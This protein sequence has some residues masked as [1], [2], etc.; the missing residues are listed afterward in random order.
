V[1]LLVFKDHKELKGYKAKK[2]IRAIKA[3]K[4]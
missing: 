3:S 4:A 2:V 1:E